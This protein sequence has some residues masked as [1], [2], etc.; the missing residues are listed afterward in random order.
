MMFFLALTLTAAAQDTGPD[1]PP[2]Y[3]DSGD[4]DTGYDTGDLGPCH[5]ECAMDGACEEIDGVCT[6]TSD[7]HCEQSEGCYQYGNCALVGEVCAP[8]ID[9]HCL[10]S[11]ICSYDGACSLVDGECTVNSDEDCARSDLCQEDGACGLL[12]GYCTPMEDA[13]CEASAGCDGDGDCALVDGDCTPTLDEHCAD[14]TRCLDYGECSVEDNECIAT[15]DSCQATSGCVESGRCGEEDGHCISNSEEDCQSSEDCLIYG[16]CHLVDDTCEPTSAAD[17]IEPCL[18]AGH[19][20]FMPEPEPEPPPEPDP[21]NVSAGILGALSTQSTLSN[22]FGMGPHPPTCVAR[23]EADCE[24]S[25]RCTEDEE[26]CY[27]DEM[28]EH[29]SD[30]GLLNSLTTAVGEWDDLIVGSSGMGF[31]GDAGGGDAE[32]YGNLGG[33][34]GGGEGYGTIGGLGGGVVDLGYSGMI[35]TYAATSRRGDLTDRVASEAGACGNASPGE[36]YTAKVGFSGKLKVRGPD[37]A[38]VI[39]L[40]D[41]L[42]STLTDSRRAKYTLIVQP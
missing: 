33:G 42:G 5:Y 3:D 6:P 37:A 27:Y 31:V 30:G 15:A 18:Y 21:D 13:H 19:C 25:R 9:E 22:L 34:A 35:Y 24:N 36:R 20:E 29:C 2:F 26:G 11:G 32:S 23:D 16:D 10:D 12:D 41:V 1:D 14:S 8:S 7:D 38:V 28:Y 40:T 39:C 17:C 4:Y